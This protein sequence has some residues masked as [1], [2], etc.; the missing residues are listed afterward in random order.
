LFPKNTVFINDLASACEGIAA[1]NSVGLLKQFFQPLWSSASHDPVE[2]Q[3]VNYLVLAMGTGLGCGLLVAKD[4]SHE[5]LSLETGHTFITPLG[6]SHP[7]KEEEQNLFNFLSNK[8]Y[9]NKFSPEWEDICSGRGLGYCYEFVTKDV[10]GAEKL[11]AGQIVAKAVRDKDPNA[12]KAVSIHYKYL[13]RAA[14]NQCVGFIAKGVFLAGDNQVANDQFVSHHIPTFKD[15]FMN[16]SK[17]NWLENVP[18]YRQIKGYNLN[19]HGT[20]HVAKRNA[21]NT[22]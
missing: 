18:V 3:P 13:F 9:Q 16:H 8:L 19:L 4:G 11:N 6:N 15:E 2:L 5:V 10:H 17:A 7:N 1:L 12:I 14:Q 20:V 22:K 21:K